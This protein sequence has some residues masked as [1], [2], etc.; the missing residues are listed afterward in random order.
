MRGGAFDPESAAQALESLDAAIR[1]LEAR[2]EELRAERASLI[3]AAQR[4]G[5]PQPA[6][7][8]PQQQLA[9]ARSA[10]RLSAHP[11]HGSCPASASA[12][13]AEA[14]A[15]KPS[16]RRPRAVPAFLKNGFTT[17]LSAE[18]S[19]PDEA[20]PIAPEPE[21]TADQKRELFLTLF[22][23]RRDVFA[24]RALALD[25]KGAVLKTA[26]MPVWQRFSKEVIDDHLC[27][28]AVIGVYP[29]TAQT[30][31]RFIVLDFDEADWREDGKA[32][33]RAARKFGVPLAPE[34]SRSGEGLHLWLFFSEPVPAE[35]ARR[36]GAGLLAAAA[37]EDGSP[38]LLSFDRMIPAQDR[39]REASQIG[40]LVALPLQLSRR[41]RRATVFTDDALQPIARQWAHLAG[42]EK[43][44]RA[45]LEEKIALL[46]NQLGAPAPQPLPR[47][48]RGRA[49]GTPFAE[50]DDFALAAEDFFAFEE[51]KLSAAADSPL[52]L[53]LSSS[54]AIRR[55][56]LTPALRAHLI[57]LAA[58]WNPEYLKR[59]RE[60]R[61]TFETPRKFVLADERH[62]VLTLPRGILEKVLQTLRRNKIPFEVEDRRA[63]GEPI[64]T[65]FA[66]KLKPAQAEA[67]RA[68]LAADNGILVASTGF[69]KT[70][71]AFALIHALQTSTMVLVHS[72]EIAK[73]WVEGAE[74]FLGLSK[75][76]VGV[77]RGAVNRQTRRLDIVSPLKLGRMSP[78]ERRAFMSGYGLLIVDECHH[79]GA[80][81]YIEALEA[82]DGRRV[83]GLT[84]TPKR[85]DG[86]MQAV[87]MLIGETLG[88]FASEAVD[89]K[90]VQTLIS[91]TA[92]TCPSNA[93]YVEQ[94]DCLVADPTRMQ[95]VRDAVEALAAR[96]RHTLVLTERVEH[97][98]LIR[99]ALEGAVENLF[100]LESG[101]SAKRRKAV[102]CDIESLPPGSPFVLLATGSLAGEGFDCPMLDALV[103]SLPISWEARLE[104]YV[105][106]LLRR[107][108]GKCDALVID[109]VDDDFPIF[110]NM[111]KKRRTGYEK[112]DFNFEFVAEPKLIALKDESRAE[113]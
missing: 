54:I 24:V 108:D 10:E 35:L 52:H 112:M 36:L 34:I 64:E 96:G 67:L 14:A 91:K 1:T 8:Q 58:F 33:L 16:P 26:Y 82:Y 45:A 110:R 94:I 107:R 65:T 90:I 98:A 70:V 62:G 97:L 87:R 44:S 100:F 11:P 7:Q 21:L 75:K 105:G 92:R 23:G 99:E 101:M 4:A 60:L 9:P 95:L 85:K 29:M 19:A 48:P 81:S 69:G 31:C 50:E 61:G 84:A 71:L 56:E 49:P 12:D 46:G 3:E 39:L 15:R 55:E 30:Q 103:I 51:T 104:Q 63:A 53:V 38:R 111:W 88:R 42:I 89:Y 28:R 25:D 66:A 106:R 74:R 18:E 79:A 37:A 68:L 102:M 73:Q 113:I 77:C 2:L 57:R 13:R 86:K 43:L 109:I 72:S 80:G 76:A 20:A 78:E 17:D 22:S 47:P 6:P 59:R 83:Y 93:S 27:G 32:V 5:S 41:Y 40:N